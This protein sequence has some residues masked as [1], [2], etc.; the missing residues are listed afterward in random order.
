MEEFKAICRLDVRFIQRRVG[1][2]CDAVMSVDDIGLLSAA[3][4]GNARS[5]SHSWGV[6]KRLT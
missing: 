6:S 3:S 4:M 5:L 1:M 2:D